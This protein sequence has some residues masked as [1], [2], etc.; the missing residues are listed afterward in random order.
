METFLH[1]AGL[2]RT[3]KRFV[4]A[5]QKVAS[6]PAHGVARE[7]LV[8]VVGGELVEIE[9]ERQARPRGGAQGYWLC[10]VCDRRCCHLFIV[11]GVLRCRECPALTYRSQ[12]VLH[13]ALTHA[14]KIRKR[15]G[16]APGVLSRL[17]PRPPHWR[18]DYWE[19]SLAD[20]AAAERVIVEMLG[21][22]MREMKRR[23]ARLD[24]Q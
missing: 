12:H 24:G 11:A 10:P 15:L 1:P 3:R 9:V 7:R 17:P 19:R 18:S 16:A 8:L 6:P 2:P 13:P 21:A 4:D 20:L 14:A 23:K 22:T 5:V